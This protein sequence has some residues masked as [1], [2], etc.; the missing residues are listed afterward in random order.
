MRRPPERSCSTTCGC[1]DAL[2]TLR[3]GGEQR[4]TTRLPGPLAAGVS[5]TRAS[6]I[7]AH[8]TC[9]LF[10]GHVRFAGR[11]SAASQHGSESGRQRQASEEAR[12]WRRRWRGS[13]CWA[14]RTTPSA[15]SG[16]RRHCAS[17]VPSCTRAHRL[18]ATWPGGSGVVRAMR[19]TSRSSISTP[20]T[21]LASRSRWRCVSTGLGA[22]RGLP[23]ATATQRRPSAA[24]GGS[25]RTRGTATVGSQHA[26]GARHRGRGCPERDLQ[27]R[28]GTRGSCRTANRCSR[29]TTMRSL[30]LAGYST[31]RRTVRLRVNNRRPHPRDQV[32]RTRRDHICRSLTCRAM[33]RRSQVDRS[34]WDRLTKLIAR[35]LPPAK[36]CHPWPHQRLAAITQGRS[37]MR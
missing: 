29:C 32:C 8:L 22:G 20:S 34:T 1:V 11:H 23:L 2:P 16:S 4:R 3:C 28:D 17:A 33:R 6:I 13:Q 25:D 15:A 18:R 5:K 30:A 27:K 10:L 26:R 24:R 7:L 19:S 37:R 14:S 9:F 31:R 35:W 12:S 21:E 36:T